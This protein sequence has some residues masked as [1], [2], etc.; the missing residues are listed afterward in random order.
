MMYSNEYVREA[1]LPVPQ[2]EFQ[3]GWMKSFVWKAKLATKRGNYRI[4]RSKTKGLRSWCSFLP[5]PRGYRQHVKPLEFLESR[6]WLFA[7]SKEKSRKTEAGK[8][9]NFKNMLKLLCVSLGAGR[10]GGRWKS[11]ENK[12]SSPRACWPRI[13]QS[14]IKIEIKRFILVFSS[15][16]IVFK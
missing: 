5:V 8:G 16:L 13:V 2:L 15:T 11:E 10:V 14:W 9:S 12:P 1:I 3:P 6:E 7:A 4:R